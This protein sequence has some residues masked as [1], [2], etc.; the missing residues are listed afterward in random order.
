LSYTLHDLEL[1]LALCIAAVFRLNVELICHDNDILPLLFTSSPLDVFKPS[2]LFV[3]N[4]LFAFVVKSQ[5][6]NVVARLV[7]C[8][9]AD[10]GDT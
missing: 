9:S 4:M 7:W 1:L 2:V 6:C 8:R 10:S 5:I 3:Q